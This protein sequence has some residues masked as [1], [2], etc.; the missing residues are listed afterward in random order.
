MHIDAHVAT[1]PVR[2]QCSLLQQSR[3]YCKPDKLARENTAACTWTITTAGV[4]PVKSLAITKRARHQKYMQPRWGRA[5]SESL[6]LV[7]RNK[8]IVECA[9]CGAARSFS[10]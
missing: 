8:E 9:R 5:I 1:C 6:N 10:R 4:L 7:Q 3:C 2:F